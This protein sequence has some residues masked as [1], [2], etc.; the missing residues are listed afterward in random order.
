MMLGKIPDI[1][2]IAYLSLFLDNHSKISPQKLTKLTYIHGM[3]YNQE[4]A[5]VDWINLGVVLLSKDPTEV[6]NA[7]YVE[8]IQKA[9]M[10]LELYFCESMR[11][12]INTKLQGDFFMCIIGLC[13][14]DYKF[15]SIIASQ[16]GFFEHDKVKE[17]LSIF[18]K[19]Q[20]TIFGKKSYG[21]PQLS[22]GLKTALFAM[23]GD[24][25]DDLD[26]SGAMNL[27]ADG[28]KDAMNQAKQKASEAAES[29]MQSGGAFMTDLLYRDL[30]KMF[31]IDDSG[32]ISYGEFKDLCKYMGLTLDE[33]KSLEMF[34]IADKNNNNCIVI[35]EFQNAMLIIQLEIARETLNKLEITTTDLVWF[36]VLTF[37]YLIL[38]LIFVFL[39]IFAFSKAEGFNSVVNSIMPLTAGVLAATRRIDLESKIEKVKEYIKS[40]ISNFRNKSK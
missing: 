16:H 25:T 38:G 31:D 30:F 28:G 10:S 26:V 14:G 29:A 6:N 32:Y 22:K 39:G 37:I 8:H 11:P 20:Q 27:I 35:Y 18:S 5:I 23:K 2:N 40:I 34:A 7:V 15:I 4:R 1:I 21:L 24:M 9:L 36:G 19:F 3:G 33:E 12:F 17:V 13:K